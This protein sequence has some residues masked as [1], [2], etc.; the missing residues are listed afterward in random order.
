MITATQELTIFQQL[1]IFGFVDDAGEPWFLLKEVCRA[2][3]MENNPHLK[4]RI[5]SKDMLS[6]QTLTEGGMQDMVY[7]NERG[8]YAAVGGS[9]KTKARQLVQSLL[10]EIPGIRERMTLKVVEL[11]SQLKEL[12]RGGVHL[13]LQ[14]I[15]NITSRARANMAI[16]KFVYRQTGGYSYPDAWR[17]LYYQLYYRYGIDL[18]ARG[19]KRKCDPLDCATAKEMEIV[20]NLAENIFRDAE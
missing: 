12:R 13:L 14:P 16:R 17:E 15:A 3:E 6:K 1:G 8:F 2:A 5:N 19:R 7:V 18:R 9:R 11:E 20:A 10:S 4:D